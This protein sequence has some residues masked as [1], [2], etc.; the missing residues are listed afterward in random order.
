MRYMNTV[1]I[2]A[3]Q[4]F[5]CLVLL[6]IPRNRLGAGKRPLFLSGGGTLDQRDAPSVCIS[7]SSIV[8]R[9]AM[10]MIFPD[11]DLGRNDRK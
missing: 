5:V 1:V 7:C 9:F 8:K 6:P 10:C 11:M 4:E 3:W 2:L